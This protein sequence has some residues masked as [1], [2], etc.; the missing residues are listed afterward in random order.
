MNSVLEEAAK[1]AGIS[2]VYLHV[3]TANDAALQF[4][5]K[6]EFEIVDTIEGYYKTISPPDCYKLSRP[7]KAMNVVSVVK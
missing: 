7:N 1:E 3:H 2:K 4:Y 6:A 5:K